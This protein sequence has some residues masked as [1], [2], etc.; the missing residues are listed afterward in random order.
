M[1][2][3][4][5]ELKREVIGLIKE[6]K[7]TDLIITGDEFFQSS[8]ISCPHGSEMTDVYIDI[9]FTE[10]GVTFECDGGQGGGFYWEEE[11]ESYEF[12]ELTLLQ[13][14]FILEKLIERESR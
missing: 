1:K 9:T 10:N 8:P 13:L 11:K 7:V 14:S 12:E 4:I 5:E 6:F 2:T 3:R